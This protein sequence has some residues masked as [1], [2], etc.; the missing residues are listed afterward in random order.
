MKPSSYR[1]KY[2]WPVFLIVSQ[3]PYIVPGAWSKLVHYAESRVL[4]G[5]HGVLGPSPM[6]SP[7]TPLPKFTTLTSWTWVTQGNSLIALCGPCFNT[8]RVGGLCLPPP[9]QYI[10]LQWVQCVSQMQRN[11]GSKSVCPWIDAPLKSLFM[12]PV[13]KVKY[14]HYSYSFYS[15]HRL[16][17]YH[18]QVI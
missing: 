11:L 4:F 7:H 6:G 12:L 15:R 3:I 13:A 18:L 8:A 5:S 10:S 14:I 9:L 16:V 2:H 17:I 1:Q